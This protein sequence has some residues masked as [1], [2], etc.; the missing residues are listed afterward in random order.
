MCRPRQALKMY[1]AMQEGI[2]EDEREMPRRRAEKGTEGKSRVGGAEAE[3]FREG[4][5]DPALH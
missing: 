3:Q 5:E 2:A 1:E 4:Q